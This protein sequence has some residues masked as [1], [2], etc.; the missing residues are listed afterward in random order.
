MLKLRNRTFL[1][2]G[3]KTSDH[4]PELYLAGSEKAN[5]IIAAGENSSPQ[6]GPK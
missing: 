4:E 3:L 2:S 5:A 6:A 1:S